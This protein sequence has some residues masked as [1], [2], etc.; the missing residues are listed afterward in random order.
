[1]NFFIAVLFRTVVSFAI[2]S[3]DGN[4]DPESVNDME[5]F[6]ASVT[7]SKVSS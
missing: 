1:M 7:V 2:D 3:L 6:T 5:I 4:A